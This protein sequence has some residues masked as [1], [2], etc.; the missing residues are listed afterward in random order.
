MY[1]V[2]CGVKLADSETRCPL[3]Q[4]KVYHPEIPHG[5]GE[6]LYP[7]QKYPSAHGSSHWGQVLLTALFA[8]SALIVLM[9]D[10]QFNYRI[11]WSGYVIGA[12]LT[13]YVVIALPTWFKKPNPV[14]FVPCDFA[15]AALYLLYINLSVNGRWFLS[16]AL[17]VTAGIGLIVVTVTTLLWYVRRGVLFILGGAGIA[18][19]AFML[20]MEYLMS[21]TFESVRFIGW[22]LY[23]LAALV[24]LGGVLIFLGICR[25]ARESMERRF[26]L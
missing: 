21:L 13:G 12:L 26:F 25:P 1:C 6:S 19:G 8:L 24:L 4:T 11:T 10:M 3:C 14:I 15:A 17:P 16:F 20:L 22:S 18:L 7:K 2:K 9:C 5:H 23:P